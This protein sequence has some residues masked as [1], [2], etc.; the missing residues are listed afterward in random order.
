MRDRALL[1]VGFAAGGRRR[2]ELAALEVG[3]LTRV[4]DGFVLAV[5]R[6]KT[7]QAGRG[8]D[9]PVLGS[10]AIAV[11]AWLVKSGIRAGR[12]FRGIRA[13]G[14]LYPGITGKSINAM[15]QRRAARAGL[16]PRAFEAHSLRAGFITEAAR[17]GAP[18]GD[19]M[20]LS[21]HRSVQVASDYY[22]HSALLANPAAHLLEAPR[23]RR[24]IDGTDKTVATEHAD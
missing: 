23:S 5:R 4:K 16:E 7:D 21:G 6:S 18:L 20:T 2:A 12:L 22:R 10:A 14:T 15:V 19:A 24:H 1:L 8:L 11:S 17:H 9:V 13:N 3:D